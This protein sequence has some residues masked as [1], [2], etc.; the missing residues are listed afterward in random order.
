MNWVSFFKNHMTDYNGLEETGED[1]I[2]KFM[3]G[4]ADFGIVLGQYGGT[5]LEKSRSFVPGYSN[6]ELLQELIIKTFI[7]VSKWDKQES[8]KFSTYLYHAL[9]NHLN[10]LRRRESTAVRFANHNAL[11]LEHIQERNNEREDY[12]WVDPP[13][14]ETPLLFEEL[15]PENILTDRERICVE[16]IF[17]GHGN[18]E[19]AER[20]NLSRVRISQIIK[21]L[22]PKLN[23]LSTS[24]Y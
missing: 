8:T 10:Y 12:S 1:I 13:S 21:S 18:N 7:T 2:E 4:E 5:L 15:I 14:Y 23:F 17:E 6:E 20:L 24:Q 3:C 22:R 16:M 11:S 19:I 9:E